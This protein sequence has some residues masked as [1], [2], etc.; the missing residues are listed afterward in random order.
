MEI[1]IIRSPEALVELEREWEQLHNRLPDAAPFQHPAWLL[2]WWDVY[3]S[4]RLLSLALRAGGRMV[5]LAPMFL[6]PWNG[7]QQVTLIGTG[8]SDYLGILAERQYHELTLQRVLEFLSSELNNWDIC[9]LQ[10]LAGEFTLPGSECSPIRYRFEPQ[11]QCARARL[12]HSAEEYLNGLPPTLRRNLRRYRAKLDE[13]GE[14]ELET[15]R[16]GDSIQHAVEV[17]FKLHAARWNGRCEQGMLAGPAERFHRNAA[18]LLSKCGKARCFVLTLHKRPVAVLYGF[19][20]H[21]KFWS[22]QTG[23]DPEFGRFSPGSLI[24]EYAITQVI[25]EG[26]REFDFLRGAEEYKRHWGAEFGTT[27]RLLLW[28]SE[29]VAEMTVPV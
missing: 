26:A 1:Q 8:A 11:Y 2:P 21:G 4:G 6:H 9:D 22:Y 14:V 27:V 19:L 13:M 28:H 24:L 16:T 12:P 3:G 29:A 25:L 20:D 7:R 17:L 15:C 18:A 23:F 5:A 10:D